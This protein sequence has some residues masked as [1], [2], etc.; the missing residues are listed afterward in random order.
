MTILSTGRREASQRATMPLC[1]LS[2]FSM[3]RILRVIMRDLCTS[4]GWRDLRRERTLLLKLEQDR[5][6]SHTASSDVAMAER[7]RRGEMNWIECSRIQYNEIGGEEM[8]W[9]RIDKSNVKSGQGRRNEN[10]CRERW[11][12]TSEL[13]Q[14]KP[15]RIVR[16]EWLREGRRNKEHQEDKRE[17]GRKMEGG[18]DGHT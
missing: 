18:R 14:F 9:D 4:S 8:A 7:G 13:I 5:T 11:N 12:K 2:S 3:L 10:W 17:R 1:L 16:N 6:D 15:D